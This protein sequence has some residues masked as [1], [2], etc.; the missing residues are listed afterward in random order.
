MITAKIIQDSA[1]T[2]FG[3]EQRVTTFELEYPR[4]I[5]SELMTHRVFSRNAASSRAIPIDKM[6]DMVSTYPAMPEVWGLNQAGMQATKVGGYFKRKVG[7][8]AWKKA[9]KVAVKSARLLQ[10]LGFHKQIVNR[11]VEPFSHI[12]VVVTAT[13]FDNWLWLRSHKDAQPEIRILSDKMWD[14]Y[15]DSEPTALKE[16]EYHVPYVT[17]LRNP[18]GKLIYCTGI[19]GEPLTTKEAIKVSASCCAQVSYRVLD[20]SLK[21]ALKIYKS[22]VE[23]VPVHASPFEHQATPIPQL[24]FKLW[25]VGYQE[26]SPEGI[27]HCDRQGFLWSGNF[28]GW[29]QNRQLIKNNVCTKYEP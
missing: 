21:K 7:E 29:I 24:A 28:K 1:H 2:T 5:H 16:G 9:A 3:V 17:R 8:W 4:F 6:L 26:D 20:E 19:G 11:V 18:L 14:L 23:S 25:D 22:L 10:R 12:K 13:N 15:N 27:T